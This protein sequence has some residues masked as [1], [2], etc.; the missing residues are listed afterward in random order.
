MN[1][2]ESVQVN[3]E[4][5]SDR[6]F[7]Y[8][9]AVIFFCVAAYGYLKGTF[10]WRAPVGLAILF[11][12]LSRVFPGVLH[13]LNVVWFKFGLLLSKLANPIVMGVMYCVAFVPVAVLL[14]VFGKD[15]LHRKIDKNA[16]SYWVNRD[17]SPSA[18]HSFRNQF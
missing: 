10:D 5:P 18:P 7:G 12:L 15:V 14:R 17:Q 2:R 4:G 11:A 1:T 6:K 13:S 16:G 3:F 8:S 9:F